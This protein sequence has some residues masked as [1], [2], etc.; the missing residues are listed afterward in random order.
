MTGDEKLAESP[1]LARKNAPAALALVLVAP[2]AIGPELAL[3]PRSDDEVE[4]PL[5]QSRTR[6]P[7]LPVSFF[8]EK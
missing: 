4:V 3:K 1:A 6:V 5:A 2:A 7:A 8:I